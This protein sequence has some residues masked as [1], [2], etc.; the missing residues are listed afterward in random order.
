MNMKRFLEL[1]EYKREH[2]ILIWKKITSNRAKVGDQVGNV[3]ITKSGLKYLQ[4]SVDKN[5]LQVHRII[6]FIE[7]GRWPTHEIDHI[8]GNGLNNKIENLRDVPGLQNMKNLTK[9]KD[10]SSGTTGVYWHKG[11]SKWLVQAQVNGRYIYGGLH[12]SLEEAINHRKT[13]SDSYGF[14]ENHGR[15]K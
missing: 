13:L 10:N 15:S 12:S 9:R 1:F 5:R 8:D 14:H 6:W 2:G 11:A 4:T 3:M 7:R